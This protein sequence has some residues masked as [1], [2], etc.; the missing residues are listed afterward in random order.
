MILVKNIYAT[1]GEFPRN[2]FYGLVTQMRRAAVSVPSNISEGYR[3]RHSKEFQQFLNV[4]L[5]SLGELETQL[6][7]ANELGY[8]A[9]DRNGQLLEQV[10][11]LVRMIISLSKKVDR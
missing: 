3:R 6:I 7:I 8:L 10:D 11:H 9:N 2:E 1:S 5:G 4:S